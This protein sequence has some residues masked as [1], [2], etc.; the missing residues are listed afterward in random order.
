M[1]DH[2]AQHLDV[3]AVALGLG[4]DFLDLLGDLRPFLLEALDALDDGLELAL[5]GLVRG[6]R[7]GRCRRTWVCKVCRW[8]RSART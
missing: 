3:E 2:L 8:R 6:C 1:R 5:G 7:R 4:E